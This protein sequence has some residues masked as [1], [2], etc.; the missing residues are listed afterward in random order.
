MEPPTVSVVPRHTSQA[1]AA[2]VS[3]DFENIESEENRWMD[4]AHARGM[5]ATKENDATRTGCVNESHQ[6]D[7]RTE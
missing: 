6:Q 2:V 5:P 7:Y 3:N 4:R 1:E